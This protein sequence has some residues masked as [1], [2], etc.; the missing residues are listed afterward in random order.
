MKRTV[1]AVFA[2]A[3]LFALLATPRSASAAASQAAQGAVEQ[4]LIALDKKIEDAIRTGDASTVGNL[5]T[6]DFRQVVPAGVRTKAELLKVI[7]TPPTNPAPP[8]PPL[9]PTYTVHVYGDTAVMTHVTKQTDAHDPAPGGGALHVFLRQQ[10]AWKM[11]GSG[12]APAQPSAERSI[13]AAGY[14]LMADGKLKEAIEL[15]KI[16]VQLYPQSWNVY[17]SL[18]EAYANSGDTAL[19]V[20]NY[21]KSVQLN[22]KNDTGKAAL[23]KL[24][25]K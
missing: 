3:L 17:D 8:P 4:E 12:S 6:D 14:A 10:G 9:E 11:A 22:P 13:N 25:G 20:Q 16:N 21:E 7:T 2:I 1:T 18:G 15:F 24:K 5:L 19:A 23:A